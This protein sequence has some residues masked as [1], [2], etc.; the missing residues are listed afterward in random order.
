MG[1][2]IKFN[3]DGLVP[4]E[5]SKVLMEITE[6]LL[7]DTRSSLKNRKTMSVPIA[8]LSTLGTGVASLGSA[9]NTVTTTTTLATD[10]LFTIANRV[11]GDTL[12]MAKNGNAWG[13]MKTATGTSKMV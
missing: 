4:I 11:A 9:F 12:K 3:H 2:I 10:G 7:L 5:D 8:E 1:D 6:G 13:A